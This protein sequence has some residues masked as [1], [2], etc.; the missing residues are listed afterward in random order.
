MRPLLYQRAAWFAWKSG[1]ALLILALG[2]GAGAVGPYLRGHAEFDRRRNE[3]RRGLAREQKE[4]QAALS[5]VNRRIA[6]LQ[7]ERVVQEERGRLAERGAA[8]LR[9]DDAWWRTVWEKLFGDPAAARTKDEMLAR[10][11]TAQAEAAARS[12]DLGTAITRATWERDG[13]EIALARMERRLADIA[14]VGPAARYYIA[15]A[16][17]Q[18]RWYLL[19]A[20]ALWLLGPTAWRRCRIFFPKARNRWNNQESRKPGAWNSKG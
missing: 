14:R 13:S 9:A 10:F 18:T 8:T 20:L 7:A 1:V 15:R 16:W 5:S 12:A 17:L 4:L 11:G 6:G 3:Q 2:L 19:A